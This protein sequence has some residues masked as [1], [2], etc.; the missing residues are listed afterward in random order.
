MSKKEVFFKGNFK[1]VKKKVERY[2]KLYRRKSMV[3][4]KKENIMKMMILFFFISKINMDLMNIYM[5]LQTLRN[6]NFKKKISK[7]KKMNLT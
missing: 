6:D 1:T 2:N 4:K 7:D 5:F 3:G